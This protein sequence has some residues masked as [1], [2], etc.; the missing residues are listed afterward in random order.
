MVE[1]PLRIVITDHIGKRENS[2]RK[3]KILKGVRVMRIVKRVRG[4]MQV[5]VTSLKL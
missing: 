5:K 3:V 4:R 2:G 1:E